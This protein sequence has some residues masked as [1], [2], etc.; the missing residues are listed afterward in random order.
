MAPRQK[1]PTS[2]RNAGEQLPIQ[3]LLAFTA[4]LVLA[5]CAADS[6]SI[7]VDHQGDTRYQY[8]PVNDIPH[9]ERDELLTADQLSSAVSILTAARDANE[10]KAASAT[11]IPMMPFKPDR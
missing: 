10:R 3:C 1:A 9:I 2:S 8:L 11:K 5:G 4:F 7:A 6:S